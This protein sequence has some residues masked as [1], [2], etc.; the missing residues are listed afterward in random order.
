MRP[1]LRCLPL[2]RQPPLLRLPPLHQPQPLLLRLQPGLTATLRTCWFRWWLTTPAT[3]RTSSKWIRTSRA[4]WALTRSSRPRSWPRFGT[5]SRYPSTRTSCSQTTP[6]STI[7]RPTSSRCVAAKPMRPRRPL[8]LPLRKPA[9]VRWRRN[10]RRRIRRGPADGRLK[11]RT[12]PVNLR[13]LTWRG[14]SSCP[15]TGGASLRLSASEWKPVDWPLSA[16]ALRVASAMHH[17]TTRASE[18]STGPTR[19]NP[20]TWRGLLNNSTGHR[21]RGSCTWPR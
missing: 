3:R 13:R 5:G 9:L 17:A 4:S 1:L 10:V 19:N 6:R 11:S 21:W 14:P 20:N 7:S 16:S 8:R 15:T 2:L 12:V 18:R